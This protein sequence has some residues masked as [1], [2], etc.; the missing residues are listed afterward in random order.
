MS[1]ILSSINSNDNS[2]IEALQ[3]AEQVIWLQFVTLKKNFGFL[4]T[5]SLYMY[6]IQNHLDNSNMRLN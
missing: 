2:R 4:Q 5:L 3:N 1:F 6:E